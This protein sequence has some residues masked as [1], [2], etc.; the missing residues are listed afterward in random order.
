MNAIKNHVVLSTLFVGIDVGSRTNAVCAIDFDENRILE[1]TVSN[2]NPG[3]LT[4]A[5]KLAS[6]MKD[7]PEFT[8]LVI[9]MEST[10]C[11]STHVATFLSSTDILM[12]YKPYVYCLNPKT[13]ANYKKSY[14]SVGS[15]DP[16][17][18]FMI[19]DFARVGRIK[20]QP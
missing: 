18:A 10:S 6:I 1:T 17:D 7:N 15:T 16:I 11:Y 3:A 8:R 20:T 2:N 19:A 5:Q 13:T 4:L 12:P 14:V 9:A